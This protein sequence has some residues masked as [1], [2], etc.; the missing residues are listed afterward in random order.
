MD[1]CTSPFDCLDYPLESFD[2]R[3]KYNKERI[4]TLAKEV[5]KG[6]SKF[7]ESPN[8]LIRIDNGGVIFNPTDGFFI[9]L[10]DSIQRIPVLQ[11]P[12]HN[13][14]ASPLIHVIEGY[15][16]SK[17]DEPV[18]YYGPLVQSIFKNKFVTNSY[19]G[20]S[21]NFIP[22]LPKSHS[23]SIRD[24][25]GVYDYIDN[26]VG[27]S[28]EV[29][30]HYCTDIQN[31]VRSIFNGF[32][33][34]CEEVVILRGSLYISVRCLISLLLDIAIPKAN[35]V[36]SLRDD[37]YKSYGPPRKDIFKDFPITE[38]NISSCIGTYESSRRYKQILSDIF[39]GIKVIV[40][41]Y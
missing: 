37:V 14:P 1:E 12:G 31:I 2:P 27:M 21:T 6:C 22:N 16:I 34:Y 33:Y 3:K 32:K 25:I 26:T 7:N 4:L 5:M 41:G 36:C 29:R 10:D 28:F 19:I 20:F 13:H 9:T 18:S 40:S 8:S 24:N 15:L 30:H 11:I 39:K 35:E 23:K 38:E 17:Y